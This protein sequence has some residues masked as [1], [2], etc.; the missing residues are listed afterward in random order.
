MHDSPPTCASEAQRETGERTAAP[1][2]A[3]VHDRVV[4][5]YARDT[6]ASPGIS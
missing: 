1:F 2:S 4:V 3:I 6:A 5:T